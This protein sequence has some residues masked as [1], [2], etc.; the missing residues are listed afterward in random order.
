MISSKS[1]IQLDL[2]GS[3]SDKKRFIPIIP[4]VKRRFN[5]MVVGESG[6]GKTTFLHALLRRYVS[7]Y[8]QD[9]KQLLKKTVEIVEI[10]QFDIVDATNRQALVSYLDIV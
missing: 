2:L 4:A 9:P 10:G 5:I 7:V 3:G 6:L 1:E 8:F